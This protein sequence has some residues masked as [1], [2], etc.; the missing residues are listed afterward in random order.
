MKPLKRECSPSPSP[1]PSPAH[2]PGLFHAEVNT[3]PEKKPR[4]SSDDEARQ[5][6]AEVRAWGSGW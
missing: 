3:S 2:K 1:S 4:V 6:A 5:L